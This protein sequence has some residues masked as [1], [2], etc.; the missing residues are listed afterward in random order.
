[1][2]NEYDALSPAKNGH[3]KTYV[4]VEKPLVPKGYI[5]INGFKYVFVF[6][7]LLKIKI[8]LFLKF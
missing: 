8:S 3:L 1:M 6:R 5:I 2:I 7:L 4:M